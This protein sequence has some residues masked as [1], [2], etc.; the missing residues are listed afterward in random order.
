MK[1]VFL[2]TS[3]AQPTE[4]RGLSCICLEREGEVLMF[5]AGEAAQIAYMKSG[6]GWNKKMKIFVTHMHGDHCVGIL[7]ILQTMSMQHRT[8]ILE[9]YGPSGIEEFIGANIKV[10]NF[11][12]SFPI[13]ISTIKE[14]IVFD[15]KQYSI[16]ACKA[17][18]SITAYSYLFEEKDKP[19]R[20]NLEK[21]KQ[22]GIPEGKLWNQL[23]NGVVIE[24]DGKTI[25]PDQVLGEKRPGKKIGISGDTMPTKDLEK[26]FENCDYV[27][28]DSTFLDEIKDKAEETCHSTAKQAATLAKNAKVKNLILT[29]FSA[30]YKDE[31]R[32]L[33]EA[34]MIHESVITAK[35]LLE[36]EIK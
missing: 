22:L 19:G 2:G 24:V 23:Q 21:A 3:A 4:H 29:H 16:S 26:F 15:S 36:I 1:L 12:L 35:D 8:E 27:V 25:R 5:D 17:N 14:G 20:F 34:K 11:G 32:H 9:I 33:E 31:S 28:F 6:L 13:L 18:H 7:G 10:L 30:R